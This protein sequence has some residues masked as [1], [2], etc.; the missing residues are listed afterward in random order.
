M[1]NFRL[2]ARAVILKEEKILF[3]RTKHGSFYFLPGGG[4]DSMEKAEDALVR[5][6]REELGVVLTKVDYIGTVENIFKG[7]EKDEASFHE[8]NLVFEASMEKY[9][10]KSLEDHIDFYWLSLDQ[11]EKEN[12]L[13]EVLKLSIIKWLNDK[14]YFWGSFKDEGI[15]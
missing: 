15:A 1:D 5:E 3:C 14:N 7:G 11:I 8:I 2:I 12:I 10:I 4:V 9:N 6:V 13:P